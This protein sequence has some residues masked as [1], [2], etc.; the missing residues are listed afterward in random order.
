[1]KDENNVIEVNHVYNQFSTHQRANNLKDYIVYRGARK[2]E[3]K[4]EVLNDINFSVKRGESIGII[5]KNG[6]GKSTMLKL[7]TKILYPDKGT[8]ETKGK[9]AC[10]IELGAGF[11]PDMTG[12]ENVYI[13]ASIFGVP[14]SVVDARM[15]DILKFADIGDYVDERIRNYSSGMYLRL[16]FSVAINV[17]AD[18]LLIDEI[19]GVGDIGFQNKCL[20]K[21][22]EFKKKG[23]TI[24]LVTHSIDQAKQMCDR[25]I[26][27][28]NGIIRDD[29][30]ADIVGKEY[31][32]YM[33]SGANNPSQ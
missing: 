2:K 5:G 12:R 3:R 25:V 20:N 7:L 27:I 32:D 26:W 28:N 33:L 31:Y 11:H 6:S 30:P 19:L 4:H 9:I 29:G 22:E 13:N 1:M 8:I 17:D 21:L 10:L 18:I 16:A 24:V 15:D 14:K 23:G